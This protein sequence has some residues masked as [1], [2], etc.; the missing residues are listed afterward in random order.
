MPATSP[1]HAKRAQP[2]NTSPTSDMN[3]REAAGAGEVTRLYPAP[4]D[5]L[6]LDEM[7]PYPLFRRPSPTEDIRGRPQRPQGRPSV[8]INMV[9]SLDGRATRNGKAGGIGGNSDRRAM[10]LLRASADAVMTGPGTLR[11]E[12]IDLSVPEDLS[13]AR[14]ILGESPQPLAVI[15][16]STGILALDNLVCP[17]PQDLLVLALSSAPSSRIEDLRGRNATVILV[18]PS[19]PSGSSELLS[20]PDALRMLSKE[21]SVE[22]LLVEGGPTLNHALVSLGLADEIFLTLSPKLISGNQALNILAGPELPEG[23]ASP[24]LRSAHLSTDG[25]LFLRYSLR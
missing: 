2:P 11:A 23:R 10:R 9:S 18:P 20:L 25:T 24:T 4:T 15:P 8:A 13:L 22:V 16:T 21:Y 1:S 7:Y 14:V 6:T 3:G 17:R 19:E 5:R 12:R